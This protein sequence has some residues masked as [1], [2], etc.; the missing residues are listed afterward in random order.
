MARSSMMLAAGA[1]RLGGWDKGLDQEREQADE[2]GDGT[3]RGG[4][5]H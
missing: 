1:W 2:R 4:P 3:S 5:S